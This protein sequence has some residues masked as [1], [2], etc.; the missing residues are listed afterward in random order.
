[1]NFSELLI[2]YCQKVGCSNVEL[3]KASGVDASLISRLKNGSRTITA[4]S[5]TLRKICDGLL[6]LANEKNVIKIPNDIYKRLNDILYE[7]SKKEFEKTKT[8]SQNMKPIVFNGTKYTITFPKGAFQITS[9]SKDYD[10]GIRFDT[11]DSYNAIHKLSGEKFVLMLDFNHSGSLPG[12]MQISINVGMQYAGKTLQYYYYNPET[13][14]LELIQS[15]VADEHGYVTVSQS[16]CSSYVLQLSVND[17]EEPDQDK[18]P[19]TG[20]NSNIF[21]WFLLVLASA[22]TILVV[23]IHRRIARRLEE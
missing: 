10:F 21:M 1:M 7:Y 16:H 4:E 5:E 13:K 19:D 14:E 18:S 6:L 17:T 22:I 20:D 2:D 15:T 23:S 11:G 3:S 8:F 9:Q 12:E